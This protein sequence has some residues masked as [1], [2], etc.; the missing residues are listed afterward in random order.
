MIVDH[1]TLNTTKSKI[2]VSLN[3]GCSWLQIEIET[4]PENTID[5]ISNGTYSTRW[6]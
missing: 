3:C 4:H 1:I 2:T 5:F 6:Q